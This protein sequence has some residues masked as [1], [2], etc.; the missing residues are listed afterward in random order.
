MHFE[1]E[2]ALGRRCDCARDRPF[3]LVGARPLGDLIERAEQEGAGADR[4]VGD[5][6]VGVGE[7]RSALEQRP[8]QRLVDQSDHR[9]DHFRRRV[10]GAGQLAQAIVVD[11]EEILIEIEPRFRPVLADGGPVHFVQHAQQRAERGPHSVLISRVLGQQVERGPDKRI[12]FLEMQRR[13]LDTVFQRNVESPR[14]QEAERHRLS[15][16]VRELRVVGVGKQ[17]LA[18]VVAQTQQRLLALRHLLDHLV[19]Q[20]ATES[21]ADLRETL[22]V[23]RRLRRSVKKVRQQRAERV[24]R[25]KLAP[26]V[27]MSPSNATPLPTGSPFRQRLKP[28][29]SV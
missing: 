18:P 28:L 29:P 1:T 16:A 7:T 27:S 20:Q 17:Q 5:R 3:A 26:D 22:G 11:F 12:G 8:T 9:A 23:G 4:R 15:V 24:R 21:R 14:H 10:V 2:D 13:Q 6:H 19:A 25:A